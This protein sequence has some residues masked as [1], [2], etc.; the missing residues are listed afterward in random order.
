MVRKAANMLYYHLVRADVHV[1]E[2]VE[3]PLHGRVALTD[4]T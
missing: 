4:D 2:Y 3:R 1:Y